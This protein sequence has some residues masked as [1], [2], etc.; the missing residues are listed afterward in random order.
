MKGPGV[1]GMD[2]GVGVEVGSPL[3]QTVYL[4]SPSDGRA[5]RGGRLLQQVRHPHVVQLFEVLETEHSYYIVTECCAGG[6]LMDHI[7]KRKKTGGARGQ[8][9]HPPDQANKP[10]DALDR[11][12]ARFR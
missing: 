2:G 12:H 3:F 4:P 8:E 11:M 6:D 9:I 10:E 1:G 7:A 5:S